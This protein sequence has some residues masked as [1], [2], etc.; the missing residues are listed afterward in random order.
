[1]VRVE[2]LGQRRRSPS[3]RGGPCGT[4][5]LR[6]SPSASFPPLDRHNSTTLVL[7]ANF[8]LKEC[9]GTSAPV[10]LDLLRSRALTQ[11]ALDLPESTDAT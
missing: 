3:N 6:S 4:L 1:M 7:A 10:S 9:F 2:M 11:Q 8:L 5:S